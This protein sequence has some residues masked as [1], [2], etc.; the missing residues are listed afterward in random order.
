MLIVDDR[1]RNPAL[2]A[3]HT[4]I[5]WGHDPGLSGWGKAK[6]G[7]SYAGWACKPKDEDAVRDW[8]EGRGDL[9]QV[10]TD[11]AI[12]KNE[13]QALVGRGPGHF[14]VYVVTDNHPA[15]Q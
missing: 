12:G 11:T 6:G 10:V 15:L 7:N 4:T 3:T 9:K 13:T 1:S 8:V 5:V 2:F 14:H